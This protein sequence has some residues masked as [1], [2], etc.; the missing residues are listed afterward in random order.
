MCHG[1]IAQDV[2]CDTYLHRT[3]AGCH[4]RFSRVRRHYGL[5]A[6]LFSTR[7][8]GRRGQWHVP[9]HRRQALLGGVSATAIHKTHPFRVHE[10]ASCRNA[11]CPIYPVSYCETEIPSRRYSRSKLGLS[12]LVATS[13]VRIP[14]TEGGGNVAVQRKVHDF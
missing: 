2:L 11:E 9:P 1:G 10:L 8:H 6:S 5:L 12:A 3:C 4:H 14:W 13:C 7:N